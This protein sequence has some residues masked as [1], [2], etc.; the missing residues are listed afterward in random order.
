MRSLSTQ[1]TEIIVFHPRLKEDAQT[2]LEILQQRKPVM[3][4]LGNLSLTERQRFVD[5]VTGGI[6]AIDGRTVWIGNLTFL[7]LPSHIQ[8]T[9]NTNKYSVAPKLKAS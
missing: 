2:V 1:D 4:S 9:G 6:H 8:V 3:V 7:F 5:W